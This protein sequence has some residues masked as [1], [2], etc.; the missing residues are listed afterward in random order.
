MSEFDSEP[1]SG[2]PERLPEGESL[3]WQG[4][5]AWR[6]LAIRA[7]HIRKIA[8]YFA[9]LVAAQAVV[10]FSSGTGLAGAM[11]PALWLVTFA[12][13]AC[14]IAALLAW[15]YART[16]VYTLTNRRIVMRY[17]AAL[18]MALNLPFREIAAAAAAIHA[19]GTAD[20]PLAINSNGRISYVHLWPHARPWRLNRPEP[21]LRSVP[22][23]ARIAALLASALAAYHGMAAQT[24]IE[25][26]RAPLAKPEPTRPLAPAAA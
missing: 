12:I 17:G 3:L 6:S 10:S 11:K 22:D 21:M 16:T 14:A 24:A 4:Q 18:P 5:P 13:A 26:N 25:V 15:L 23:G 20:I 9:F 8:L 19:D 2:L 7:F 1:V